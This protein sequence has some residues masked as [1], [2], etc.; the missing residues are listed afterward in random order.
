MSFETFGRA[1]TAGVSAEANGT[2]VESR[3]TT[4]NSRRM[5]AAPV[6]DLKPSALEYKAL[7][8]RWAREELSSHL[9]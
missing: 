9:P 1:G 7:L 4:I 8:I 5:D 3:K 6:W 2:T